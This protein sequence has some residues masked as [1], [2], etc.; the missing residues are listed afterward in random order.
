[1]T[2]LPTVETPRVPVTTSYHGVDVTEEYRWLE[3][4]SSG[5]TIA[6][7]KAQQHLT[8]TYYGAVPWRETL[9]ARVERLL[10]AE[11]TTYRSLVSGGSTY[12]A[13]KEQTP[14]QQ[15]FLVALTNLDDLD[16][17]RIVMDPD[18][19][20]PSGETTI[21]WFVPSPDGGRVAVSLSEHGTEDGSLHAYDIGSGEVVDGPIP[22][23]N[24]KGGSMAWRPDGSGF[25]YTLCADPA[26]FRQQVCGSARSAKFRTAW[27]S[28]EDPRRG[29]RGEFPVGVARW[30]LGDGSGAEG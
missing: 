5:D 19:I 9:R 13:L 8:G 26:G 3:D 14:R 29:H 28:P 18:A 1:M 23:V 17:E 12:F 30:P 11:R 2:T 20:D 7:T 22:H 16:T 15:P 4:G 10:R 6:W 21:D 24:L 27:T 25:W